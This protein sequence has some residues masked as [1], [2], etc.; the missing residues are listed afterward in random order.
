MRS[1]LYIVAPP[2]V[3]TYLYDLDYHEEMGLEDVTF[4]DAN[5]LLGGSGSSRR[6]SELT[7][8]LE[9]DRVANLELVLVEHRARCFAAVVKGLSGW[10][11]V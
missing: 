7:K 9:S 6:S 10:K 1:H 3:Q 11:I 2:F 4:L 5:D 8:L